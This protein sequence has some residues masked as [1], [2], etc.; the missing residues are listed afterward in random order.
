MQG[1]VAPGENERAIYERVD[2]GQYLCV[3]WRFKQLFD[4]ESGVT[5]YCV[6]VIADGSGKGSQLVK[7]LEKRVSACESYIEVG[8]S[9]GVHDFCN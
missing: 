4:S 7:R 1:K 6:S 8:L 9:Y 5:P 3:S 2:K